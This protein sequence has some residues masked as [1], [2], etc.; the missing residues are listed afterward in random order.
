LPKP[1]NSNVKIVKVPEKRF[2]V[3]RFSWYRSEKRI[4]KIGDK[5][6]A[7]LSRDGV[8]HKGSPVYAGYNAPWTPPWFVRNEVMIE[9]VKK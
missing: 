2:A 6:L 8:E 3:I 4:N 5:L 1:L 7:A 9:I